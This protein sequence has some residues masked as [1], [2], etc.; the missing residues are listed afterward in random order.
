MMTRTRIVQVFIVSAACWTL[1]QGWA[2]GALRDP[3]VV[4]RLDHLARPHG[5]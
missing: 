2:L 3:D 5:R 4:E 1:W